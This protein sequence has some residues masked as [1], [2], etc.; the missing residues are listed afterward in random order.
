MQIARR[1]AIIAVNKEE[2]V[3]SVRPYPRGM[4]ETSG[5]KEDET[6][7]SQLWD[8]ATRVYLRNAVAGN[9]EGRILPLAPCRDLQVPS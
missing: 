4:H 1:N 9:S 3:E 7:R 6:S 2:C 8:V 5:D